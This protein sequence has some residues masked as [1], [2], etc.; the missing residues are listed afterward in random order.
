VLFGRGDQV[1]E[2]EQLIQFETEGSSLAKGE[3]V[4]VPPP[5]AGEG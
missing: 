2:G 4:I 5:L 3:E 1:K